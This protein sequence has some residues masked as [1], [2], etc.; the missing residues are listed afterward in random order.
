MASTA[1]VP[2]MTT[3]RGSDAASARPTPSGTRSGAP[4]GRHR[5]SRS[6]GRATGYATVRVG[7][8]PP[9]WPV[10]RCRPAPDAH[11]PGMVSTVAPAGAWKRESGTEVVKSVRVND[12]LFE[13]TSVR[14]PAASEAQ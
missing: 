11:A 3:A 9:R 7:L 8:K 10:V 4:M 14:T 2:A 6:C 5:A 1:R 12:S 13:D